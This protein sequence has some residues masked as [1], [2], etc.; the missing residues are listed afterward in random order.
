M[1][2][3]TPRPILAL[4]VFLTFVTG[5]SAF[6][7]KANEVFVR[8]PG[9]R[10]L[11]GPRPV[12]TEAKKDWEFAWL[13]EAAYGRSSLHNVS[14]ACCNSPV[15]EAASSASPALA[16]SRA[17]P[18]RADA[19]LLKAGWSPWLGFPDPEL[20][21][22]ITESNL[23]V[24]VWEKKEPASVAVAF[25]GTVF[26]SGKDWKSNLR[27][28]LPFHQYEYTEI[29]SVFGPAFAREFTRRAEEPSGRYLSEAAVYSTGHSLGG[30]LAQQFA[31]SLPIDASVP[32]VRHVCAF[33][34]S[35]VTGFYSVCRR[36]R[37][38]NKHSLSI[39]RIYE[40]GEILAIA[41]S[42]TSSISP[43]SEA[44]PRIRGIRYSLFYTVNP[45]SGHSMWEF[46]STLQVAAGHA[47]C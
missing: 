23:R 35:P 7:Q 3:G 12:A 1:G 17:D 6:Q 2:Q 36:T 13:S 15:V 37:D 47:S 22:K 24:E 21:K 18:G 40:R 8:E 43:P 34:P 10:F 44:D 38:I 42:L 39:D 27:W 26:A 33:D 32:R 28:F 31:Y 20:S 41:R 4:Q 19:E 14:N 9:S 11:E 46:A 45:I 25:G 16:Q 30:G 29:V 5:R